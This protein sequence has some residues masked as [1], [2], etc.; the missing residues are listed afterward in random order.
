[1]T[2]LWAPAQ[3]VTSAKLLITAALP[4][5]LG[6]DRRARLDRTAWTAIKDAARVRIGPASDTSPPAGTVG[7][8][9]NATVHS[10]AGQIRLYNETDSAAVAGSTSNL[11]NQINAIEG[12]TVAVG[13]TYV[14]QY[15]LTMAGEVSIWGARLRASLT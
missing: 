8:D 12:I 4:Q 11:G 2:R 3:D 1:M 7:I 6:G 13:K 15:R 9:C 10:G 14:L 5:S